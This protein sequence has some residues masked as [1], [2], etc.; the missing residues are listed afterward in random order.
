MVLW[1][2]A[3]PSAEVEH[4]RNREP[5]HPPQVVEL[6]ELWRVGGEE[7]DFVFGQIIEA[8]SDDGGNVYLLDSQLCQVEVF[9]PDGK[10]LRTL[11]REGEGPGETRNPRDMILMP[12]GSLGI[13]ELFPGRFVTLSL[14]G[15]PKGILRVGGDEGPDTGFTATVGS[16]FR[17][18]TLLIAGQHSVPSE[19][20]QDRVQYLARLSDAGE[21]IVRY[22]EEHVILDFQKAHFSESELLPAFYLAHTV[23][24]DGRLYV[25]EKRNEYSIGVYSKDGSLER[26]IE[27]D[28]ENWQRD[29]RDMRRMNALFD[30][31]ASQVPFPVTREIDPYE[32]A[33]TSLHVEDDGTLWVQHSRSGRNQP[34]GVMLTYDRFNPDG[35]YLQQVS[36]TCEGNPAFD[37]LKFLSSGRVLLIKSFVLSR[38][39]SLDARGVAFGEEEESGPP[40][41]ICY[42]AISEDGSE[43]SAKLR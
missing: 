20:G 22:R 18:G 13:M 40:E 42:R 43:S 9:S 12:D 25:A 26:V 27:R 32:Q 39:A 14:D 1:L 19:T 37:G 23:G 3:S 36:I 15:E 41:V 34:D 11:S 4:V 38:W 24:P 35:K 29:K 21:E 33:I 2:T 30:T 17:G 31:W 7:G 28:F 10:H 16:E 6:D 5:L 8:L